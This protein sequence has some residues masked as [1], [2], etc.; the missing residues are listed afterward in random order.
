MKK[1]ILL[2][3]TI[4]LIIVFVGVFAGR[5]MW[6]LSLPAVD[7]AEVDFQR[8][9]TDV[10]TVTSY[11]SGHASDY[12]VIYGTDGYYYGSWTGKIEEES[13]IDALRQLFEKH[14]YLE[15][16]KINGTISFLKGPQ[17]SY[18]ECGFAYAIENGDKPKVLNATLMEP[19]SSS[20]WYYYEVNF[21][22]Q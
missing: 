2:L 22:E 12:I 8:H 3:I 19:V 15:V 21:T 1:S 20:G 16:T 11:L 13:V 7:R 17:S 18:F 10:L 4:V 14:G 5:L 9:K 6:D